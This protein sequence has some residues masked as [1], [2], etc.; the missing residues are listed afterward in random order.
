MRQPFRTCAR[1]AF[2]AASRTCSRLSSSPHRHL[3]SRQV[4][5]LAI[6]ITKKNVQLQKIVVFA[7]AFVRGFLP[8]ALMN[9]WTKHPS[10]SALY[11]PPH[12]PWAV[13]SAVGRAI[14]SGR[15]CRGRCTGVGLHG[16][17]DPHQP[18]L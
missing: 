6:E 16:L 9:F 1:R 10:C 4:L 15:G 5:L 11:C 14:L 2:S 3:Y 13:L 12:M 18:Y 17:H 7:E 8:W